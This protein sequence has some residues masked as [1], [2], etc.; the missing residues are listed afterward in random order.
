[1]AYDKNISPV[2]WYLGSYLLR[3][4][5]LEDPNRNDPERKF[6]SWENTVIVRA[7]SMAQAFKKV[8]RIGKGNSKP[9]RGGPDGIPVKWEFMGVT[10]VLPI[11]EELEDGSEISWLERSPRTLRKLSEL[12]GP[13]ESFKQ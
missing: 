2:D 3:F 11:Y 9:Y 5:E 8:E 12:V 10:D 4:V 13:V 1:M 6:L 7:K